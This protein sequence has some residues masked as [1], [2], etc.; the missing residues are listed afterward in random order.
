ME[1][2]PAYFD[3]NGREITEFCLVRVF[4]FR[5][6]NERGNGRQNWYMYKW[7]RLMEDKG[8]MWWVAYHLENMKPSNYFALRSMSRSTDEDRRIKGFEIVQD[9][10]R[11]K[12]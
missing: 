3:E 12:K 9:K 7:V 8:K 1:K 5:G 4:H 6:V 2:E 11:G 10:K